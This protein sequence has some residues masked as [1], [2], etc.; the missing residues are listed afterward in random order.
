MYL[1]SLEL[2]GFKSFPDKIKLD[3]GEGLT[4]V[5]GPNGSG[6]SNI[7]DAVRWVLGEQSSKSLRGGK[8]EDVIFSGTQLRKSVGFA[9]VTLNI[10]NT[11]RALDVDSDVVSVT[12]KLYR[13]GDS[14]YII[15]GEQVR[16]KDIV[17]MF[18]DTGLG[19]DGYSIIGQGKIEDIVSS[20]STDRR[21]IFEEAAGIS[22]FRHKKADA[23]RK[24]LAAED[25]ILRLNDILGE[26]EGRVGPL[27]SQSEK[28]KKYLLLRDERKTLE[29]SLWVKK[30]EEY[31]LTLQGLEE[32]VLSKTAEYEA[33]TRE[34]DEIDESMEDANIK[35]AK[36]QEQIE[37]LRGLI[38]DCEQESS[39]AGSKI[40]VLENDIKHINDSIS[41]ALE[42]IKKSED[43]S[44]NFIKQLDQKDIELKNIKI[45][46]TELETS[47]AEVEKKLVN[48]VMQSDEF[49]KSVDDSNND[50]N[51]LYI[52]K[53]EIN[54]NI[55]NANATIEDSNKS[56][57]EG[58]G[59]IKGVEELAEKNKQ[60]RLEIKKALSSVNEKLSE[61]DNK[62]AGYQKLYD[63]KK[64][65][66]EETN[67]ELGEA[68][69]KV[70]ELSQKIN[71]L[72]DLEN[73]MEGFSYSVK[74]IMKAKKQSL[75][76]GIY[77]TIAGLITVDTKYS[78]AI[79]TALGG[80]MQNI[81][82]ENEDT[83]KRAIRHL[84][85]TKSGRAT[86]LPLTSIKSRDFSESGLDRLDGFVDMA[87]K[88]VDVEPKFKNVL[89]SLLGRIVICEDIDL[90]TTIAKKYL[91]RFKIVTLDGQVINAGGSFTGGSMSRS[92]GL[93]TR[94]NEI[95]DNKAKAE[96]I[97]IKIDELT[98]KSE[99]LTAEVN[100]LS[101]DI[102]GEKEYFSEHRTDKVKF[103]SELSRL[104]DLSI[105]YEERLDEYDE[106]IEELERKISD[107]KKSI[108]DN[109][110][111]LTKTEEQ[112]KNKEQNINDTKNQIQDFRENRER[113]S[114][115]LSDLKIKSIEYERDEQAIMLS[116]EQLEVNAENSKDKKVQL[117]LA[118][119]NQKNEIEEKTNEI[120]SIKN[121]VTDNSEKINKYNAEIKNQ[122]SEY[123]NIEAS[124]AKQRAY[125]KNK[126][127][128][129][130]LVSRELE[131]GAEKKE[132][133]QVSF[134]KIIEELYESYE[135][136]RTEAIEEAKDIE[137]IAEANKELNALKNK[138]RALGNVNLE[139][140][141]EYEEVSKRY[142]FM[143]A[144]LGDVKK[145]KSELEKLIDEL[146]EN[147][148]KIFT[149]SFEEINKNFKGIFVDLFGG[150]T[151]ELVLT[152]PDNILESGIEI[153][154]APP[155]KVI[156]NI[157]SLSGGEKS[158]VAIAIFMAILKVK[159]S[160]FC[161]LDEIEA[162]LDDVN[163]ARYANYLKEYYTDKTQF[164]L[165]TH[166]RGTMEACDVL[167]GVTMQE[168][169]IS[170]LLKMEVGTQIN[171]QTN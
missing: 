95:D 44:D 168:K 111:L 106:R 109:K 92:A 155:G 161:I 10:D 16:L 171:L 87:D 116:I 7:G 112:I 50:I 79:E 53:S 1:K 83:A 5:V 124:T 170:K 61:F 152:D 55:E 32:T 157:M 102:E 133:I 167:Y 38:H 122:Q 113:L 137:N 68:K 125:Q 2:H 8:M 140:I 18:M 134:D 162:A 88:L 12:R 142:E 72:N 138:M 131:R 99:E 160:P 45:K 36:C 28:A 48:L 101:Y 23:E 81:V 166:R 82:V 57:E 165:V 158:F 107:T 65:T 58:K 115:E 148:K 156:K 20:K 22:K 154:V 77:G 96:K 143:N 118:I 11:D 49:D 121:G 146:T 33:L 150:G 129:K 110:T 69:L 85:E 67:K 6:K 84:K 41:E 30:L 135:L 13:N 40:A 59:Y 21:E 14:E 15:N 63:K 91:Y 169:G 39:E 24:L 97:K 151:G 114:K 126:L 29:I 66:L 31:K 4:G 89:K 76:S 164:I 104:N 52:K 163:V 64:E 127:E 123:Q 145:S 117:D 62:I 120:N 139:S 128:E 74:Q 105:Q 100:K 147:M 144:Q 46:K 51:S 60:E 153:N 9:S 47:V 71:I 136:T 93:L 132:N 27:K 43:S 19:K 56:I 103:E 42:E 94:K 78:T 98:A 17:E 34:V 119:L 26:L 3:F 149:E 141:E 54:F 70:S 75:I 25:N 37:T 86:F 90:A 159:P 108:E 73:S 80:A 35:R 130:E